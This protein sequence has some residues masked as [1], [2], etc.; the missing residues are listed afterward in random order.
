MY[1]TM[2]DLSSDASLVQVLSSGR[3]NDADHMRMCAITASQ[4]RTISAGS[5]ARL[6]TPE[7][8]LGCGCFLT[9]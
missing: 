2:L 8:R 4:M 6:A 3:G 1:L 5:F 7:P 9:S